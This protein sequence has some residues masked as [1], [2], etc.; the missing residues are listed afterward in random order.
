M[1][2]AEF[3]Q[4][5][6]RLGAAW[7]AK[8]GEAYAAL[9]SED[10]RYFW[11]PMDPPKLGRE[12]IRHAFD[13]AVSTQDDIHFV[14]EVL[15]ISE[16]HGI[17]RWKCRFVRIGTGRPVRIDGIL[18]VRMDQGGRCREFR[19]WWHTSENDNRRAPSTGQE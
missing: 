17:A 19:E 16:G 9:F 7:E 14:H 4:W 15:A 3:D 6:G 2:L 1:K 11:T 12:G 13:A 5:L 8:D 10:A 18:T